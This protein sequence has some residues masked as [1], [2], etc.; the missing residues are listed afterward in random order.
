MSPAFIT[1]LAPY[2]FLCIQ[3]GLVLSELKGVS[4]L[5]LRSV[6]GLLFSAGLLLATGLVAKW[7]QNRTKRE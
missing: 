7:L 2:N 6:L 1:G 4:V 5:D 3:A